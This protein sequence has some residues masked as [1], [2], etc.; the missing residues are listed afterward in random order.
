MR[1]SIC[2]FSNNK[3]EKIKI[4][5]TDNL[6]PPYK[7]INRQ[8]HAIAAEHTHSVICYTKRTC[9]CLLYRIPIERSTLSSSLMQLHTMCNTPYCLDFQRNY[10]F[11]PIGC[12]CLFRRSVSSSHIVM[13]HLNGFLWNRQWTK[14][15]TE[16]RFSFW[17][18]IKRFFFHT[19]RF[20]VVIFCMSRMLPSITIGYPKFVSEYSFQA[21]HSL[22]VQ[23][24]LN[25]CSC[26]WMSNNENFEIQKL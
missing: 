20:S 7:H 15:M 18:S 2:L 13:V 23:C 24:N 4:F 17:Y 19:H 12:C 5:S 22:L 3:N 26:C 8:Q 11:V 25:R 1:C 6:M 14:H 9:R 10:F 16:M 21:E